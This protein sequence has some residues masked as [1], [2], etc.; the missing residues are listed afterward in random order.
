MSPQ[1]IYH[2][3]PALTAPGRYRYHKAEAPMTPEG[4]SNLEGISGQMG[5]LRFD[6]QGSSIPWCT[7]R[8]VPRYLHLKDKINKINIKKESVFIPHFSQ[9]KRS[10]ISNP[11]YWAI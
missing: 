2:I 8:Q 10:N 1:G 3:H 7:L 11:G 9:P 6:L 4:M 5:S